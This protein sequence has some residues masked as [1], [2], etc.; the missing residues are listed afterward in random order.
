[1]AAM[2]KVPEGYFV[3]RLVVRDDAVALVIRGNAVVLT[4]SQLGIV[5][6]GCACK[7][8]CVGRTE[9]PGRKRVPDSRLELDRPGSCRCGPV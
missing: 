7:Q 4:V 1:M 9:R 3:E 2:Q 8:L 6:E 5:W